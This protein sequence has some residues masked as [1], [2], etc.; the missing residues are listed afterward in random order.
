MIKNTLIILTVLSSIGNLS[1]QS[2]SITAIEFVE[3]LDDQKEEAIFYYQHNWKVLRERAKEHGFVESFQLIEIPYSSELPAHLLLI[4]HFRNSEQYDQVEK[5][6][7][8]LLEE[9]GEMRLLNTKQPAV[10]RKNV[11]YRVSKTQY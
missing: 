7:K 10:F 6:F 9:H 1:G 11:M 2:K 5:N 4:T 3:I 8:V